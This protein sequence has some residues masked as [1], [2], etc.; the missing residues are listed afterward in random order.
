MPI[1]ETKNGEEV[2]HI[3]M[4]NRDMFFSRFEMIQN[5]IFNSFETTKTG[6]NF[7]IDFIR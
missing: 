5:F 4:L 6:V 1:V 3:E 2:R 7:F